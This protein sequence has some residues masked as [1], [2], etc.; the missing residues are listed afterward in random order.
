MYTIGLMAPMGHGPLRV[1]NVTRPRPLMGQAAGPNR[2]LDLPT[3]VI[4]G[5]GKLLRGPG[6]G[7]LGGWRTLE[8]TK[9][10]L[11]R[12]L[13]IAQSPWSPE[14]FKKLIEIHDNPTPEELAD[15]AL[16][17]AFFLP[18]PRVAPVGPP[19]HGGGYATPTAQDIDAQ[20]L[21]VACRRSAGMFPSQLLVASSRSGPPPQPP[22]L[23]GDP[24]FC[25]AGPS[26]YSHS[27]YRMGLPS[28]N[29]TNAEAWGIS[30]QQA[31]KDAKPKVRN[32]L[33][34]DR[35]ILSYP[36]PPPM[37][38]TPY[39]YY[40]YYFVKGDLQKLMSGPPLSP[41]LVKFWVTVETLAH[42]NEIMPNIQE[43]IE[44][45]AKS[46]ARFDLIRN[47]ALTALTL[48]LGIAGLATAAGI[49]SSELSLQKLAEGGQAA[50]D[51]AIAEKQ[52]KAD[53]AGFASEIHAVCAEVDPEHCG[54]ESARPMTDQEKKAAA[55]GAK[56]S[57]D[58]S[59]AITDVKR[60]QADARI[61]SLE[62]GL[63]TTTL[64]VGGGIVVGAAALL[65][66]LLR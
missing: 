27:R 48:G 8:Q 23:S 49:I 37:D 4:A 3:W 11:A 33:T 30:D 24:F 51:L 58:L 9:D 1:A 59:A 26:P 54:E 31:W 38:Q 61:R 43:D 28:P 12:G 64:A 66:A 55:E 65:V 45:K 10:E 41:K 40:W 32:A 60:A 44:K 42:Y 39:T 50:K 46:D 16:V 34:L 57:G 6:Q 62:G 15:L 52:F 14:L 17:D 20:A 19:S 29:A 18:Q 47:V 22:D 25:T 7:P 5:R 36:F 2:L 53:A 13:Q 63:S 56:A 21:N 35:V